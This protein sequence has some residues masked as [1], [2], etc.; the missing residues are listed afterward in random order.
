MSQEPHISRLGTE[1][2]IVIPLDLGGIVRLSF[3][4]GEDYEFLLERGRLTCCEGSTVN[5]AQIEST[6]EGGK[7]KDRILQKLCLHWKLLELKEIGSSRICLLLI[8][9]LMY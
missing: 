2:D 9:L 7:R 8:F 3:C 5:I 4:L 6:L 1:W